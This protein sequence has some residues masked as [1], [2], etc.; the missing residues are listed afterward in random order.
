MHPIFVFEENLHADVAD[1]IEL[2]ARAMQ[3]DFHADARILELV[4]ETIASDLH[5]LQAQHGFVVKPVVLR[6]DL[7]AVFRPLFS[8]GG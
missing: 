4:F 5:L 3:R 6:F 7:T 2:R 1:V 8:I